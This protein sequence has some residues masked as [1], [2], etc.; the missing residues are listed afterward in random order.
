MEVNSILDVLTVDAIFSVAIAQAV[1]D[2]HPHYSKK[3]TKTEMVIFKERNMTT[4]KLIMMV[5]VF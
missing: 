3:L 4:V 1:V 2:N 5:K